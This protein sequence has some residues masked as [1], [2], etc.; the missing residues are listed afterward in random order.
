MKREG[1]KDFL[2]LIDS[3]IKNPEL[4]P[5]RVLIVSG[6]MESYKKIITPSRIE[7]IRTIKKRKPQTVGELS[8][9]VKRPIESVSRDLRILSNYGFLEF[10]RV[11]RKKV[12]EVKKDIVII[13]LVQ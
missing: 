7:L 3:A 9:E 13:P 4:S 1:M 11:G 12:P 5:D 2:K 10:A 6:K 8:K